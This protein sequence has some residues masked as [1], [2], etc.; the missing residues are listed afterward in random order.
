MLIS[1]QSAAAD[2]T[3][4]QPTN[5]MQLIYR[6]DKSDF[7]FVPLDVSLHMISMGNE[8]GFNRS[9]DTRKIKVTKATIFPTEGKFRVKLEA[10]NGDTMQSALSGRVAAKH[11]WIKAVETFDCEQWNH[12]KFGI[13]K[14]N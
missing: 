4:L 3:T 10:A 9:V 14:I 2:A 1:F 5:T 6:S 8:F 12:G 11:L 7:D 13:F